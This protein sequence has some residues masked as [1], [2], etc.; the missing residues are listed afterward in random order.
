MLT[1]LSKTLQ[2]RTNDHSHGADHD[3]PTSSVSLVDPRG[4]G[5]R[6][7]RSKLVARRDETEDPCF[8]I[9]LVFA[10]RGLGLV[11]VAEV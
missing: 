8:Y 5:Y 4:D 1:M 9:P 10:T 11:T 3:G 7:D 2:E 6:E